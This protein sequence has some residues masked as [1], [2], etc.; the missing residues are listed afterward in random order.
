MHNNPMRTRFLHIFATNGVE[1]C[2]VRQHRTSLPNILPFKKVKFISYIKQTKLRNNRIS[3]GRVNKRAR[4]VI[5]LQLLQNRVTCE[6][7]FIK[8]CIYLFIPLYN[9]YIHFDPYVNFEKMKY[10]SIYMGKTSCII[11][12]I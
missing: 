1:N 7:L 3:P 9:I 11:H 5:Y 6:F 4:S 8:F 2:Q 10:M 12:K